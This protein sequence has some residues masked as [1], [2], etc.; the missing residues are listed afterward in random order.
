MWLYTLGKFILRTLM[1]KLPFF[2]ALSLRQMRHITHAPNSTKH[3]KRRPTKPKKT[4]NT[5]EYG[6]SV[7]GQYG[8]DV[9]SHDADVG[10]APISQDPSRQVPHRSGLRGPRHPAPSTQEV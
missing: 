2:P 3:S 6:I 8:I 1:S 7:G 9:G 4:P 5:S 10:V